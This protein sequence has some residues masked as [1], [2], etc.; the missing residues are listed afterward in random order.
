MEYICTLPLHGS[1][2]PTMVIKTTVLVTGKLTLNAWVQ[3][4]KYATASLS[5]L[6][7]QCYLCSNWSPRGTYWNDLIFQC[8]LF[9]LAATLPAVR[10]SG[11]QPDPPR[12]DIE[13]ASKKTRSTS[14]RRTGAATFHR[15]TYFRLTH[16]WQ[17]NISQPNLTLLKIPLMLQ[18]MVVFL[19][20]SGTAF[21]L[22]HLSKMV[23]A[24][25]CPSGICH[26]THS[27]LLSWAC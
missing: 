13:K 15:L 16:F 4:K 3:S 7:Y 20:R 6:S 21:V 8:E 19:P 5:G 11:C 10:S 26:T 23:T 9:L 27:F 25:I 18:I 1:Y 2:W 12:S 14:T 22:G 17:F 24:E